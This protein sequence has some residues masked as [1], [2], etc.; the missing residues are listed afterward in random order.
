MAN[1]LTYD[2]TEADA[3]E[4]SEEEL[5]ALRVGEEL[6]E[7]QEQLLAGKYRDAEE[8]EQAYIELQ[9]KLGDRAS[10]EQEPEEETEQVEEEESNYDSSILDVIFEQA[11]NGEYS[12]EII[13]AVSQMSGA[14]V[15]DMLL[16]RG[17]TEP[18]VVP[19]GEEDIAEFQSMVGGVDNYNQM[20]AWAADNLPEQEI[21]IFDQ[22][23]ERGD[24]QAIYFAIQSLSYRYQEAQGYD[25]E[26]LTGRA[27]V[28]TVDAF[29][30]QAEVVRAMSDPRYDND[31]A[32][33]Q[34]VYDKI[35]RS[36]LQY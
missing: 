26:L 19:L 24:P 17:D 27:A 28:S 22:V 33:R 14:D 8:L 2:P 20:T 35:E 16:Q 3:P 32:Y 5:D 11:R 31:P 1:E 34:D 10:T 30:S 21:N 23:M 36:N 7:Q 4:F 15:I 12:D 13:Q 18:S 29:R 25:G 6:A 9:R